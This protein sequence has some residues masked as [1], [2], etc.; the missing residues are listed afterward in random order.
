MCDMPSP[1]SVDTEKGSSLKCEPSATVTVLLFFPWP[2][3]LP[4][5]SCDTWL[6]LLLPNSMMLSALSDLMLFK[7]SSSTKDFSSR[8]RDRT[9]NSDF[10]WIRE[11]SRSWFDVVV[12]VLVVV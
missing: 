4:P 8:L 11:L 10:T 3:P 1:P 6:L 12:M 5:P 2:P 7:S 9:V